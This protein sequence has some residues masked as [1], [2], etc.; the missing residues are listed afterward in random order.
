MQN[1]LCPPEK[2]VIFM[3]YIIKAS[4]NHN[5]Y[6]VPD[7]FHI[8]R[9][10]IRQGAGMRWRVGTKIVSIGVIVLIAFVAI[11]GFYTVMSRQVDALMEDDQRATG[12]VEHTAKMRGAFLNA[13]LQE[14][15]FDSSPEARLAE[16]TKQAA[17]EARSELELMAGLAQQDGLRNELAQA[18]AAIDVYLQRFET[19]RQLWERLGYNENSGLQGSLR[20]AVHAIETSLKDANNDKLLAL[21]LTLRRHEKDFILRRQRSYLDR[22]TQSAGQFRAALEQAGMAAQVPLLDTYQRDFTALV[23]GTLSVR[24]GNEALETAAATLLSH[25]DTLFSHNLEEMNRAKQAAADMRSKAGLGATVGLLSVAIFSLVVAYVIGRGIGRPLAQMT[26]LMTAL[27]AGDHSQPV[28]ELKRSDEV[29]DMARALEVFKQNAIEK[30]RLDAAERTR[31]ETEQREAAEARE[32]DA[33]ISRQIAEFCSA[34]GSGALDRRVETAGLDGVF[35]DLAQQMNG[36]AGMLQTMAGELA[37]V[38]G[39][40]ADGDLSKRVGGDYGGVFGELKHSSNRMSDILRDFAGKLSDSA[41]AAKLASAEIS[42]GSLDLAQ[43]T[44]SQAASIEETAASMHEI[45]ATVKQN[46]DNAQAAS[47]LAAAARDTADRGGAITGQA[48]EAV[49][50][51]ESSAQRISEIVGLMDEIAFQTNLLA[52]NASVEAARAGEAGKGFAVVAQEVR[53]LAQRSA[54]ASRDIKALITESNAQVKAGASLV[55]QTGA[56]LTEIVTAIKK[57]SDIVSEIAAASREQA[58]G[59]EQINTAVAQMDEM[60]QRNGA[61]VEETSASAQQLANQSA[62]LAELVAF[63]RA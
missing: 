46:A 44:E 54:N 12:L 34:I 10:W 52:L 58:G 59:L 39:A 32:R 57:V 16:A 29:A 27:A 13:R 37:G 60:T 56:A 15:N 55:N 61:L 40:M 11:A 7:E 43:R 49:T 18:Q 24:G 36:L 26:G 42:A 30:A 47:Q 62:Q 3:G 14:R 25:V 51:I 17:L 28:P 45:T 20:A 35:R 38:M 5:E 41:R 4:C 22:F 21:M 33:R 1:F 8:T 63:F 48:V 31:L 23:E 6:G 19:F 53:G 9:V 50:R 2:M